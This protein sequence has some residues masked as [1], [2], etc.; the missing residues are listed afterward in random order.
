KKNIAERIEKS[1]KARLSAGKRWGSKKSNVDANALPAHSKCNAINK[2][3]NKERNKENTPPE[4]PPISSE[5]IQN[6]RDLQWNDQKIKDHLITRDYT[7]AEID[8]A[9]GKKF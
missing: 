6:L 9:M 7:E 4:K 5:E 3:R 1:E 8:S 2:E